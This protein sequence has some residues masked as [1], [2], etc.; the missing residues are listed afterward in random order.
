[1][2]DEGQE[3]HSH[4]SKPH[5]HANHPKIA[6]RLKRA[7]GHL[8][9]VIEMIED[10]QPCEDIAQQLHAV[11]KAITNAKRALIHDHIDHCLEDGLGAD[12]SERQQVV[13]GFKTIA[14]Y[15]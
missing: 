10:H 5:I 1:M 8:R 12:E 15:L 6:Q 13:D 7:S 9:H 14:K 11:E 3:R 2:S 4:S